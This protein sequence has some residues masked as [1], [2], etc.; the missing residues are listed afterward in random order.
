MPVLMTSARMSLRDRCS[1]HTC[2]GAAQKRLTV[3]TPATRAPGIQ[4]NQAQV[5]PVGLADAGLG[6][7]EAHAGNRQDGIGGRRLVIHGHGG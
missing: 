2:T 3:N 5:A 1:R 6:D 4:R 7:A